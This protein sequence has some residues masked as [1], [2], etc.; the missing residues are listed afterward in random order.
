[1]SPP[2][3]I[4]TSVSS[5]LWREASIPSGNSPGSPGSSPH[6]RCR[7]RAAMPLPK[8]LLCVS[9]KHT[10]PEGWKRCPYCGYDEVR[11][12]QETRQARVLAD[13]KKVERG[14]DRPRRDEGPRERSRRRGRRPERGDR[15]R[16]EGPRPEGPRPAA[17]Q[18]GPQAPPQP[19][20]GPLQSEA[21][22]QN[23][24][25]RPRR[26]RR[27]RPDRPRGPRPDQPQ[28]APG[29]PA[30]Q[31]ADRPQGAEPNPSV[32]GPRRRRRRVR[33]RR[34]EAAPPSGP[35]PPTES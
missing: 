15:A 9:C 24:P 7:I 33:R 16:F 5:V 17:S 27:P 25:S 2:S 1:M 8:S 29:S 30:T 26:N 13:K 21:R 35:P 14:G 23:R 28:A 32:A 3:A 18:P 22:P 11:V 4:S 12:K 20:P 6:R 19:A 31:H 34:R 10:Y